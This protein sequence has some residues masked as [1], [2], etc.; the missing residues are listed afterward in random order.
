M[1]ERSGPAVMKSSFKANSALV[2]AAGFF[3]LFV[4]G[5]ARFAIGLTLKPMVD[6]FGWGRAELGSA[7]ALFQ[8]ISAVCM[9]ISGQLADR[10]SIR[11][12][13][14]S[15]IVVSAIGIGAMSA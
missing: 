7:V 9:F 2:L 4:S 10:I 13:L 15:G 6:E 11:Y 5:G 8:I 1:A 3:S 12:V 14:A